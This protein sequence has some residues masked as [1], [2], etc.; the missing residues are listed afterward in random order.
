MCSYELT[1]ELLRNA[2][3]QTEIN[4]SEKH[5]TEIMARLDALGAVPSDE[6]IAKVGPKIWDTD[7]NYAMFRKLF[8]NQM[9]KLKENKA[10]KN[11]KGFADA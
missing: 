10:W 2:Q 5:I 1:R 11:R 7:A 8:F 4:Y 9:E 6:E 3:T